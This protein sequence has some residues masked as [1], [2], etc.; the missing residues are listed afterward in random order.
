MR[1]TVAAIDR[2]LHGSFRRPDQ[3][4]LEWVRRRLNLIER[5]IL[6]QPTRQNRSER[7]VLCEEIRE[8]LAIFKRRL[9]Q[10]EIGGSQK[11]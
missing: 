7:P 8:G 5:L 11:F 9:V 6:W 1:E 4:G 3:Q 2:G 10:T